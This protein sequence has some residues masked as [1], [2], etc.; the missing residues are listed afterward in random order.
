MANVLVRELKDDDKQALKILAKYNKRSLNNEI[1]VA[2]DKY[3][4]TD[5]NYAIIKD[6]GG[7]L[8]GV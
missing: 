4:E 3:M 8:N 6:G 2:I 1:L 5:E 7:K